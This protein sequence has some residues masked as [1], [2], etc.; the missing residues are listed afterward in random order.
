[1]LRALAR[2]YR[3]AAPRAA[4]RARGVFLV[5]PS[6][7]VSAPGRSPLVAPPLRDAGRPPRR[8]LAPA[9]SWSSAAAATSRAPPS[10]AAAAPDVD[11]AAA[12]RPAILVCT[13]KVVPKHQRRDY[14]AW[15]AEGKALIEQVLEDKDCQAG[16]TR[17]RPEDLPAGRFSWVHFPADREVRRPGVRPKPD[18]RT[19][20]AHVRHGGAPKTETV[21]V[22]FQRHDD[23]ERWRRSRRREEWLRR[24]GRFG[25]GGG[26]AGEDAWRL[27]ARVSSIDVDDGSLGG[28]LPADAEESNRR[29]NTDA[30]PTPAPSPWK[31][32]A[33]VVLAQYPLYELNALLFLPALD[34]AGAEWFAA[35]SQP[36]RG[37][38][39]QTWTSA[40]AVFVTLPFAQGL[41]RRFGF[42]QSATR[43][44]TARST[45]L[46][47]AAYAGTVAGFHLAQPAFAAVVE[48]V[49]T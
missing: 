12:L 39:V 9:L 19:G 44:E 7:V 28:W 11:P 49:A 35:L 46:V 25:G 29:G 15:L 32:Y 36:A 14:D 5:D 2:R 30:S 48:R 6:P 27:N 34:A 47:A 24:G 40:G 23:L 42:M 26:E 37:F 10:T 17:W 16:V 33:A 43:G 8:A 22:V 45:A 4:S 3:D 41:L 21:A 20:L 31:V 38:V 18:R 13:S 1:M